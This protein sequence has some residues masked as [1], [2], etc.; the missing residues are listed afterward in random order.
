[1]TKQKTWIDLQIMKFFESLMLQ[2]AN[3]NVSDKR[4]I[5]KTVIYYKYRFVMLL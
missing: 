1:M 3:K 4:T 2:C 5:F